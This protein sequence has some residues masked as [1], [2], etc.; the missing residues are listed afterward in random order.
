M[1]KF[2]IVIPTF[3]EEK[4][5]K[6]TLERIY[7]NLKRHKLQAEI[8]IVDDST[9]STPKIIRSLN[10]KDLT[11]IYRK[12]ARG[13]GSAIREGISKAKE[14]YII[15][16]MADAPDDVKYLPS[17]LKRLE[18]GYDLVQTSRFFKGC[19]MEG[20]P[21][22]KRVCNWLCNSFI[23]VSFLEF[24]LKDFSSLFKGFNRKKIQ[25]LNLTANEFDLGLEIVLKAMKRR[26][27]IIEVP[28]NWKERETGE[29]KL[30]LSKYAKNYFYRVMK[31][32]LS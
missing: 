22:K 28:V 4:H 5:I 8:I 21:A 29:S 24:R 17:M 13:V 7:S 11:L 25:D 10:L 2:S 27:K 32:W 26:Y 12:K 23:R 16:L 19:K 3:N 9:D 15:V 30:K 20:Y 31:I 6:G 18:Q 1:I 14:E